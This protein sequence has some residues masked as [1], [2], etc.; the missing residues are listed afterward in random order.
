MLKDK[1]KNKDNG[2]YRMH[3]KTKMEMGQAYSKNEEELDQML[4]GVAAKEGEEFKGMTVHEDG[5]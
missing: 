5:M 4:Y 2:H 1:E 3:T